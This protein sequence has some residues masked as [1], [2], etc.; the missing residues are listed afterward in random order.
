MVWQRALARAFDLEVSASESIVLG[1]SVWLTYM[2]DRWLDSRKLDPEN[3]RTLRHGF[4]HRYALSL[5]GIWCILLGFDIGLAFAFLSPTDLLLGCT[6]LS[7]CILYTVLL[8]IKKLSRFVPKELLVAIIFSG[9]ITVFLFDQPIVTPLDFTLSVFAFFVLAFTNCCLL[10]VAEIEIDR[11]HGH[12]SLVQHFPP[13][14]KHIAK[15][16]LLTIGIALL[17]AIR[18]QLPLA[19]ITSFIAFLYILLDRYHRSIHPEYLRL[20]TDGA[21]LSA[22][23]IAV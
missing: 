10:S 12:H 2:G 13:F 1:L 23:L 3:I 19:I 9:G 16:N 8:Q 21:L 14:G 18:N 4:A 6:L 7:L 17:L 5:F 22:L 11:H 15:L 20:I